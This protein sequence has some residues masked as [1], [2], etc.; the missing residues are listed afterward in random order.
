M[1]VLRSAKKCELPEFELQEWRRLLGDVDGPDYVLK[2]PDF[3]ARE[4]HGLA[5]RIVH[6]NKKTMRSEYTFP[7]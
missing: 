3:Y 5:I 7:F 6:N 1:V 4:S 2:S